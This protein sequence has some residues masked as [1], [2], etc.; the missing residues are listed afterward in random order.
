MRVDEMVASDVIEGRVFIIAFLGV[1]MVADEE[2]V[3]DTDR[4][5]THLHRRIQNGQVQVIDGVATGHD[6]DSGVVVEILLVFRKDMCYMPS[7]PIERVVGAER[8][9]LFGDERR[10]DEQLCLVDRVASI[11]RMETIPE[12]IQ[13]RLQVR[14]QIVRTAVSSR[15]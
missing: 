5:I 8:L 15:P 3:A 1:Y 11:D 10:S 6:G 7:V 9:M 14:Q 4:F 13:P 2:S 12:E